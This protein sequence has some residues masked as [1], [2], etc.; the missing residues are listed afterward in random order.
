MELERTYA[1]WAPD[2]T[3]HLLGL[4]PAG[5]R[6]RFLHAAS[7]AGIRKF[8][9]TS[10]PAVILSAV[11]DGRVIGLC[12]LH[13]SGGSAEI[14]I[15]VEAAHR[16]RGIG[17]ALFSA[18]LDEARTQGISDITVIYD[19]KNTAVRRLCQTHGASIRWA[20]GEERARI[21]LRGSKDALH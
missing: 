18:A 7:D 4:E 19:R 3:A 20:D 13:A 12:E 17:G 5:R 8:C 2:L 21:V 11:E 1:G 10:R 6:L 15:S 9:A 14:G 16:G